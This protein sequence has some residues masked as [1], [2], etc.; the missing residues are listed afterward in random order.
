MLAKSLPVPVHYLI[1]YSL[2][3]LC[4]FFV[5][6]RLYL[7]SRKTLTCG[8]ITIVY[9]SLPCQEFVIFSYGLLDLSADFLVHVHGICMKRSTIPL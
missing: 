3:S 7:I 6:C 5:S 8:Q 2:L 4:S 1:A 9:V